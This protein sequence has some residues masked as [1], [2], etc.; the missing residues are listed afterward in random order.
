MFRHNDNSDR[1]SF[2]MMGRDYFGTVVRWT[3]LAGSGFAVYGVVQVDT[4][5]THI[6]RE[7][8]VSIENM[9]MVG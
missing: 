5:P 1:V 7:I 6:G 2:E 9:R 3:T 4:G 8:T